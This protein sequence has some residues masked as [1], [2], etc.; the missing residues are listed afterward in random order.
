MK[1]FVA[2][3]WLSAMLAIPLACALLVSDG[4][5]QVGQPA[6]KQEEAAKP[7]RAKSRG[8]LPPYYAQF[9]SGEQREEI[10]SIQ[11][12]YSE[13]IEELQKQIEKLESQ[14]D[15]EVRAVLTP[16]QQAKVDKLVEEAKAKS[17]ARQKSKADES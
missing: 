4:R 15:T 13:Q 5:S 6:T 7:A 8:R 17:K 11:T 10:Y 16:E 9:C 1:Q 14:R 2:T 12:K 3:R